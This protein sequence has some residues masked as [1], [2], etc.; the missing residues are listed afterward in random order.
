VTGQTRWNSGDNQTEWIT[1]QV[2]ITIDKL[3]EK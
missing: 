1:G 2:T 3:N